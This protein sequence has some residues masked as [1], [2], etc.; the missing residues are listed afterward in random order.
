MTCHGRSEGTLD[1]I[2]AFL[3]RVP[4]SGNRSK[5]ELID[6]FVYYLTVEKGE[7]SVSASQVNACFRAASICPHSNTGQY[8]SRQSKSKEAKFTRIGH[9]YRLERSRKLELDG[10]LGTDSVVRETS[11][12]LRDLLALLRTETEREFLKETIDCYE[13]RAYRAA[14]VM[15][16]SLAVDHLYAFILANRLSRFNSQLARVKDRRLK[17]L[18]INDRDDFTEIPESRFIELCRSAGV[19]SADVRKILDD[20][21]GIR[22]SCAHPSGI[23]ISQFKATE[24]LNDL[25]QNVVIKYEV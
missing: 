12:T 3:R 9:R 25:I 4:D 20:K 2:D 24:F 11:T 13:V 19:I 7:P 17:G 1:D 5:G 8:L 14:I 15:G 18:S 21:L 6:Q 10:I 22:N 23:K 16:W